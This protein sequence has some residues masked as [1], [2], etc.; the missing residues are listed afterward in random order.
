MA[1]QL[2]KTFGGLDLVGADGSPSLPESAQRRLVLLALAAEAGE[3]GL[4]RDR[5]IAFLWPEADE[6][7]A[8]RSL[9]QLRYTLRR[10]VGTD[11]LGHRLG[12]A[13]PPL[14]APWSGVPSGDQADRPKHSDRHDA[15]R[16]HGHLQQ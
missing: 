12:G 15:A 11:P 13:H 5:A 16:V 3:R 14:R 6:E 1:V 2:L 10:E 9:N 7:H 4:P 8:R